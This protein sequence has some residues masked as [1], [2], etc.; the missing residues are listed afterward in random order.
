MT[1]PQPK[2][3]IRVTRSTRGYVRAKTYTIVRVDPSD[4]TLIA[5]DSE[6]K[7]GSWIKW[8]HCVLAAGD[9]NWSWLKGQLSADALELL[10]AFEGLESLRLRDEIRDHILLQLP[11]LKD[12][13]LHSQIQLEEQCGGIE[14]APPACQTE[15]DEMEIPI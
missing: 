6:G 5:V 14:D 9:I 10:S 1:N 11:G 8:D 3:R 7:E 13:I 15:D 2:Q 4:N 12:R